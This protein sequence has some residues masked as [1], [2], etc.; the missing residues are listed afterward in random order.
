MITPVPVLI[1]AKSHGFPE[2]NRTIADPVSNHNLKIALA[3]IHKLPAISVPL[4]CGVDVY[5]KDND[6]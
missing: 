2:T 4:P 1:I 5:R 3:I 6:R